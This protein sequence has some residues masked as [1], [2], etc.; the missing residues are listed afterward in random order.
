[1]MTT[2]AVKVPRTKKP[3]IFQFNIS[4]AVKKITANNEL[5]VQNKY[6]VSNSKETKNH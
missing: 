3:V 4:E 1:M 5:V 2:L 6:H